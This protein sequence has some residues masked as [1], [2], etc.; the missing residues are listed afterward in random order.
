[1]SLPSFS[2]DAF[3]RALLTLLPRGRVWSREP[4]GIPSQIAS[5][6]APTY[7]RQS[8]RAANLLV[9]AFP[10]TTTELLTEWQE[11]LGLP[12][13]CAG[14]NPTLAQQRLQIVSRLTNTGGCSIPYFVAFAASLGYAITI[15]EF[16]PSRF[17]NKFGMTF[18]GDDLAYTWQVNVPNFSITRLT[19][20]D[21]F[22]KPFASWGDTVLQCELTRVKPAHTVLLFNYES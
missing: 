22:G 14:D 2:A 12:D 8:D 7:E 17:G 3:R 16:T 15:T 19:F 5:V 18:G 11:T 1:M 10:A 21:Q 13:P 6:W 4:D 20:G 9:D